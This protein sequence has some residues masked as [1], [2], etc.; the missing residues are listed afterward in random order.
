MWKKS[1]KKCKSWRYRITSRKRY[2]LDNAGQ[3][4]IGTHRGCNSNI[5]DLHRPKPNKN[6][7]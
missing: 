4:H 6:S 2:F 5:E 7:R 1:Q 3:V